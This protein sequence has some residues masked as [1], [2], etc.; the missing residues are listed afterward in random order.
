MGLH[1]SDHRKDILHGHWA[2]NGHDRPP[3]FHIVHAGYPNLTD[4]V[5]RDFGDYYLTRAAG[6]AF[7]GLY[8][9][10]VRTADRVDCMSDQT[11]DT[12]ASRKNSAADG[13]AGFWNRVAQ[14]IV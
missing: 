10:K 4:C 8:L 2:L 9:N 14:V 11:T 6:Q 13:F 1:V 12:E 5:K 7:D 3:V